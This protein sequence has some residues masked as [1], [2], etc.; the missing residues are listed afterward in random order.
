LAVARGRGPFQTAGSPLRGVAV[1]V[2]AAR[3]WSAG[4]YTFDDP[5]QLHTPASWLLVHGCQVAY[6][7]RVNMQAGVW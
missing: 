3:V 7:M 4:L 6:T 5:P 1:A 2:C